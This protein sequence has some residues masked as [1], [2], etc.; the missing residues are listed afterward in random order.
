MPLAPASPRSAVA[1]PRHLLG[2][3]SLSREE[4]VQWLSATRQMYEG[5]QRFA[6]SLQGKVVANLFFEDSTRTRLSFTV[7]AKRLGADAIDL[8]GATSSVNKGETLIDTAC[9]IEAMGVCALVVRARQSGAAGLIAS[10]VRVPVLNAGDGKH[11]HPTQG[12][13]D[14]YTLAHAAGRVKDFDLKGMRV[15]IVGDISA[16]RVARSD[17]AALTALGAHVTCV[18]SPSLAPKSLE[19]LGVAVRHELDSL[20]PTLDAI[21]MLRIQFERY[22]GAATDAKKPANVIASVR[23]YRELYALTQARADKLA[24]HCVVMHPG[25]INRGIELDAEVADGPRSLILKQVGNG[26]LVRMAA[27]HGLL[28]G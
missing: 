8:L 12:L 26:V 5:S 16:S 22:D 11:E 2:L 7:A 17:I 20:L 27:L 24:K 18:G 13:L 14:V 21:I 28:V 19:S 6:T 9:N 1:S 10:R 3:Q 25:P 23:E 4:I 15:A